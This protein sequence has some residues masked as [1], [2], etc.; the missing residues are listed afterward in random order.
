[1]KEIR[2]WGYRVGIT[3]TEHSIGKNLEMKQS[4]NI[5]SYLSR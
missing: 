1:M 2:H 3:E 4:E 5:C